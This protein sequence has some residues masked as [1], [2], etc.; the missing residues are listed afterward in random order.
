[1]LLSQGMAEFGFSSDEVKP[2]PIYR[3]LAAPGQ[4]LFRRMRVQ[5]SRNSSRL[6][7]KDSYEKPIR[8]RTGLAGKMQDFLAL[9]AVRGAR[10]VGEVASG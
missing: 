1:M 5:T 3:V 6:R 8:R 10:T 9:F 4:R 2:I 7:N